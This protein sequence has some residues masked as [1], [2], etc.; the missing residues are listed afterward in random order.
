MTDSVSTGLEES[1]P[2]PPIPDDDFAIIRDNGIMEVP[3]PEYASIA[4][5]G[6]VKWLPRGRRLY[7]VSCAMHGLFVWQVDEVR[8]IEDV[9]A[10]ARKIHRIREINAAD[11]AYKARY[12]QF[13]PA[14]QETAKALIYGTAD[15]FQAAVEKR[16][17][18]DAA[19][20]NVLPVSFRQIGRS[21]L[22]WPAP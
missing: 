5:D 1:E 7:A 21:P 9:R 13:P 8:T 17:A 3:G 20:Q 6:S 11:D 10:I 14:M 16:L 15:D 2:P 22:R 4:D 18:C 12:G 19:G